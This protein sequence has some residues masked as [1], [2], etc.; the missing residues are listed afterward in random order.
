MKKKKGI[1]RFEKSQIVWQR[2]FSCFFFAKFSKTKTPHSKNGCVAFV[3]RVANAP[4]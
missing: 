1:K 2:F 4:K 3:W